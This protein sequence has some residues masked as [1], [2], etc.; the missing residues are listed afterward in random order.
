MERVLHRR[1]RLAN[2]RVADRSIR[3]GKLIE[4]GW[5]GLEQNPR[6]R[7]GKLPISGLTTDLTAKGEVAPGTRP[8]M[9]V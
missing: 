9:K 5:R 8:V 2:G 1:P 3:S 4:M 7:Q 6:D